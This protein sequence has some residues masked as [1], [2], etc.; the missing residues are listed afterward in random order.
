MASVLEDLALAET[1]LLTQQTTVTW[2]CIH[3]LRHARAQLVRE[4]L[5]VVV[6]ED[7]CG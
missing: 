3:L 1:L 4:T 7:D 2:A 5:R 6:P